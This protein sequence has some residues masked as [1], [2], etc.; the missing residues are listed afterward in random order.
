MGLFLVLNG[1]FQGVVRHF[2][3]VSINVEQ[4]KFVAR[5]MEILLETSAATEELYFTRGIISRLR[6]SILMLLL[7]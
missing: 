5:L 4:L 2:Q 3:T 1:K 6:Q 7:V